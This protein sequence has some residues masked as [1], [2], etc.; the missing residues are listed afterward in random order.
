MVHI[1][2]KK[3]ERE[4]QSLGESLGKPWC[5][6][7]SY[8]CI[9]SGACVSICDSFSSG[10]LSPLILMHVSETSFCRVNFA[11]SARV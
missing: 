6:L 9:C 7:S 4:R 2:L 1:K 10:I 8:V 3:R 11:F 5:A